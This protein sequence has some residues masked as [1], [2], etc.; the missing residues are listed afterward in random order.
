M[1]RTIFHFKKASS[2]PS[3]VF[4]SLRDQTL[5]KLKQRDFQKVHIN[6]AW[7]GDLSNKNT[8]ILRLHAH[9]N[10]K[11]VDWSLPHAQMKKNKEGK[12]LLVLNTYETDANWNKPMHRHTSH[13]KGFSKEQLR[14]NGSLEWQIIR[15]PLINKD[16]QGV[17]RPLTPRVGMPFLISPFEQ[18][19]MQH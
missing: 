13:F 9:Q 11:I 1:G 19:W 18:Y 12:T 8:C 16:M 15:F 5:R 3:W 10:K 6:R 7:K 14:W 4:Q 17:P 2:E